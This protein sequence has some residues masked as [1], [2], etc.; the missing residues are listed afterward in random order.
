MSDMFKRAVN[1]AFD[2]S[3]LPIAGAERSGHV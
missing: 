3:L 2:N 1:L